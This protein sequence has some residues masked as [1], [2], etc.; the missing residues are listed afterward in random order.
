MENQYLVVISSDYLEEAQWSKVMT[1]QEI[2]GRMDMSDCTDER[3]EALWLIKPERKRKLVKA[4]F[5]GAWHNWRTP[6]LMTITVNGK[7]IDSGYGTDH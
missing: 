7:V 5:H 4:E 6:L 3:I 1:A 2:F